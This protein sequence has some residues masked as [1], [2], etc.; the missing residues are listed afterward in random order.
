MIEITDPEDSVLERLELPLLVIALSMARKA[1]DKNRI[2]R[3]LSE[4]LFSED[5]NKRDVALGCL[6]ELRFRDGDTLRSHYVR[7]D[8]VCQLA[9]TALMDRI[10][11]LTSPESAGD[12]DG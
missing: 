11:A 2:F 7:F 1:Q 5:Q 12:D 9:Q 10:E 3:E 4:D 6:D 8:E